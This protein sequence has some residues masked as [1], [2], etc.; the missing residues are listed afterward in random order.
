MF[1]EER[2]ETK[3]IRH[4]ARG[5]AAHRRRWPAVAEAGGRR[6]RRHRRL[7]ERVD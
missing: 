3:E 5:R 2:I 4:V 7:A 1:P 6:H